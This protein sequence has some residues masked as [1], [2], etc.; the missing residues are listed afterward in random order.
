LRRSLAGAE[1][2]GLAASNQRQRSGRTGPLRALGIVNIGD[3][4][5][6]SLD[7]LLCRVI[8]AELDRVDLL[9]EQ[10]RG[11]VEKR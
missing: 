2:H 8:V 5:G 4:P 1:R 7:Q 10:H 9:I 6:E 3:R 11:L